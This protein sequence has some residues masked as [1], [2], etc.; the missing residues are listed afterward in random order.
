VRA[1]VGAPPALVRHRLLEL[2]ALWQ[3]GGALVVAPA[4]YGKTTLLGQLAAAAG[5]PAAYYGADSRDSGA[6]RFL[7]SL[8]RVLSR[9]VPLSTPAWSSVDDATTALEQDLAG[10]ALLLVD[11]FH[12]LEATPAEEALERLLTSAPA[13]LAIVVAA[14]RRPGINWSRLLVSDS[15]LEVGVDQLRFR[16]WEVERLFRDVYGEPLPPEDLADLARRT[17]GWAAGLKLFHL[18]T[19]GRPASERR[20]MLAGLARRWNLAREYL[21]RNVL[22]GL[23]DELRRFLLDTSVLTRLSGGL[24]DE[25]LGREGSARFLR[26]LEKRQLFTYQLD[27][28]A[29]RYHEALRSQLEVMLV[30]QLGDHAA[31]ER[32]RRVG[33]LLEEHAALPDA[34]RAYCRAEEW[35]AVRRVLG[36]NGGR[37]AD[38]QPVWIDDLP[39]SLLRD[40]P[41]LLLAAA[42]QH[43]AAGRFAVALD[44]YREAEQRF[45]GSA[46]SDA[47][48]RE[49][50][51]LALWLD[52][53]PP[54]AAGVHG[55][56]RAATLRDPDGARRRAGEVGGAEGVALGGLAALLA[57][58]CGAARALLGAAGAEL[59]ASSPLVA[60]T[61]LGLAV[62]RLLAGDAAGT[63]TATAAAETA[64]RLGL[65][66]LA[67]LARASLALGDAR[68]S[69]GAVDDEWG[70]A[71]AALF[72][73]LGELRAGGSA[74]APLEEAVGR[75]RKLGAATLEAWARGAHALA[76][77]RADDPEARRAALEAESFARLVGVAAPQ[78][79]SYLALAELGLDAGDEYRAL[80]RGIG[81]QC[82]L[83]LPERVAEA[84]PPPLEVRCLG[85]FVL[86]IDGREVDLRRLLKPRARLLLQL[87]SLSRGEP[88][89][90]EALM[91]ALWPGGDAIASAR[92]L[93]VL[94]SSVRRALEPAAARG[95]WT[96]LVREGDAYR[97][98]LSEG[99]VVDLT[100]F[101]AELAAAERARAGGRSEA[102]LDGYGR[103]LELYRG[104]LLASAGPADWALPERERLRAEAAG[105]ARR[106]AELHLDRRDPGAAVLAC[107]RGLAIDRY[108]DALWRLL[109]SA[110][111]RAGD[112]A[113]AV[114]ARRRYAEALAT[115]GIDPPAD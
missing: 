62:A 97:L 96:I 39:P 103:A 50:M 37:I 55:L 91:E 52:P 60:A 4:G 106:S 3:R 57:G 38:E 18:A 84:G 17:E 102:A 22:D 88:V 104:E 100:A 110:H 41:S 93:H 114:R 30:E 49:R 16:S 61:Q 54:P 2:P 78:A 64:E 46:A 109:A 11:D 98:A 115:L 68:A 10:P 27:D 72:S 99:S 21:T 28:G 92:N 19:Q 20:S 26:E 90:R 95:G 36:Q 40:D 89:H 15:L 31:R 34:L 43:R 9:A 25:L 63:A 14:R 75:F 13:G 77:A 35:N 87:L 101:E 67:R 8:R 81:E 85:V 76:L 113:S 66:W 70:S 32:F 44:A 5:V 69:E 29:Y 45:V 42:R 1:G 58:D 82:S 47:C 24:C 83:A 73:G 7:G 107:E 6:E 23:D 112:V 94:I 71:L 33:E 51:E 65:A 79:F 59:D 74:P 12:L 53:S 48:H 105:A 108:D 86:A 111:V 56:L 80:A